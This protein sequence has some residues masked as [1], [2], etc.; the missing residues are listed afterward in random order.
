MLTGGD[1]IEDM[2]GGRLY[3]ELLNPYTGAIIDE[4]EYLMLEELCSDRECTEDE[5]RS[6]HRAYTRALKIKQS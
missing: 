5:I 3:R 4:E 2:E 1:N 6:I